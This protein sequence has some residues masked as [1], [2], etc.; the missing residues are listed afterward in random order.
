MNMGC[1]IHDFCGSSHVC[2]LC[3]Y[4]A[5][6]ART[7][8]R[9]FVWRYV[10]RRATVIYVQN[11]PPPHLNVRDKPEI[12]VYVDQKGELVHPPCATLCGIPS[13]LL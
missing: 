13:I 9:G 2:K 4:D 6:F 11:I 1:E 7:I 5:C 12:R 10:Y 3:M 8:I